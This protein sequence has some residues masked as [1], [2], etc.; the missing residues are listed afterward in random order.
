MRRSS[1]VFLAVLLAACALPAPAQWS[2]WDYDFDEEKKSWKE[3][4]AQIPPYPKPDNLVPLEVGRAQG[5][6]YYVDA[7]SI[8]RG[9]DGVMRYTTVIKAAGGA[10][11]VTFEGMRC[12]TREHKVYALGRNDGTWVRAR[13]PKWRHVA[14]HNEN[15]PHHGMLFRDYFC[16]TR[17][18]LPR[19]QDVV[20]ALKRGE[21]VDSAARVRQ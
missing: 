5:H 12:E 8:S 7:A 2:G 21:P 20:A 14:P 16:P 10:S 3:I 18:Q 9:E 1:R 6:R 19:P 4:Q 17:F 15:A 11:N 13:D